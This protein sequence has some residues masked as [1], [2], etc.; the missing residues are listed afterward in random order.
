MPYNLHV[1]SSNGKA[2]Q[3]RFARFTSRLF[4]ECHQL[5]RDTLHFQVGDDTGSEYLLQPR[6]SQ[7]WHTSIMTQLIRTLVEVHAIAP[8][9][10]DKAPER[11]IQKQVTLLLADNLNLEKPEAMFSRRLN[12]R[13]LSADTCLGLRPL[14]TLSTIATTKQPLLVATAIKTL[15]NG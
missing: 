2:A 11:A 10:E 7:W 14:R 6:W 4:D 3:Y 15:L 12:L 13:F 8:G 1:L 5:L 9:L